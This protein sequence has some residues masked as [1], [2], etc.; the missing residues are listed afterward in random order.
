MSEYVLMAHITHYNVSEEDWGKMKLNE[1]G[2]QGLERQN[3]NEMAK[4]AV[5]CPRPKTENRCYL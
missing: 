1:P 4:L 5:T 2:G 3:C